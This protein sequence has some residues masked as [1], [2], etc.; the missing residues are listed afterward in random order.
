Y[1]TG[2]LV[3]WNRDGN[4]EFLGRTDFQVKVRGLRIELGEIESALVALEEVAQAVVAVHDGDVGRHLVGY[5]VPAGGRS[6][7]AEAVREAVGRALPAY[8]VPDAVM[9]LDAFPVTASEKVDRTALPPP[10]WNTREF[11]APTT[12]IQQVVAAVFADVLGID[13]VG[14]DDDFFALGGNSLAATRV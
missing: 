11:R 6:V 4:L 7:D 5:V 12:P 3:R 2:D 14:L 8:M 10:R 13:R 1:R 9:V